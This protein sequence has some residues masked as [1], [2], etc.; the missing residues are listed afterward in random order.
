[1]FTLNYITAKLDDLR[2]WTFNRYMPSPERLWT[3]NLSRTLII[4]KVLFV[5]LRGLAVTLTFDLAI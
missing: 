3:L 4:P 5:P 1:M 2:R